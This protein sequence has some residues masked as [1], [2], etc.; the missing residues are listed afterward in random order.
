MRRRWATL[1]TPVAPP[2]SGEPENSRSF[3][4]VEPKCL[5]QF[6]I[7]RSQRV[8]RVAQ[9]KAPK[10]LKSLDAELKPTPVPAE[11]WEIKRGSQ[12]LGNP[13]FR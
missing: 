6:C 11:R 9:K 10:A 2:R 4:V 12:S 1:V 3:R 13:T 7:E 5:F 8:R